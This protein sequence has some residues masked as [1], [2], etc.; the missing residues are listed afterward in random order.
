MTFAKNLSRGIAFGA[1]AVGLTL[2][3][4]AAQ[5]GTNYHVLSSDTDA[6][7]IG[8]GAGGSTTSADGIGTWVPGEDM[9][10]SHIVAF[11]GDFGYRNPV[12]RE[13][14]CILTF[15]P[16]EGKIGFP[17]LIFIEFDGMN[18]NRPAVF[19]KPHCTTGPG[20]AFFSTAAIPY[21]GGNPGY[22]SSYSFLFSLLPS[23][24]AVPSSSVVLLP[25]EGLLG[26][27]GTGTAT[28]IAAGAANLAIAST[29]F[30][31]GVQFTWQPS[32]L[33]FT[34]D[35]DGLWH[36]AINSN[37]LTGPGGVINQYW[38]M[39]TDEL[40]LWQSYSLATTAGN[41]GVFAFLPNVDYQLLIS[42]QS[43]NT[44]AALA[45]QGQNQSGFYYSQ[46]EN[47]EFSFNPNGGFD[48]G[49][50]SHAMSLSGTK[51]VLNPT[52]LLANQNPLGS[53]AGPFAPTLGFVTWDNGG[54]LDGSRRL[55]WITLDVLGSFAGVPSDAYADATVF[56]GTVRVPVANGG[57]IG[58][59]GLPNTLFGT[60]SHTTAAAPSGW[61]DAGGFAVGAF[62]IPPIAGASIQLPVPTLPAVCTAVPF[63]LTYGTSGL[64]TTTG[65]LTWDDSVAGT[66]GTKEL[67]LFD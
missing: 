51:G 6:I 35:I 39:S 55:P 64:V 40:G 22:T 8:I 66:S 45:P 12:F 29:G 60:F 48:V 37:G 18:A 3:S 23:G 49:R 56:G 43:P 33:T 21:G 11:S 67:V 28:V 2:S 54:D 32:A 31:W 65:P 26:A 36:Y 7:F 27:G 34:D 20:S 1:I 15:A 63:I 25:D 4:A 41:T 57:D 16:G 62:G 10:G 14:A 58:F 13:N 17:G 50:G 47:V 59:G 53:G 30:C 42:S 5:N 19:S 44:T 46:T 9:R 38:M 61:P 52:S 24:L